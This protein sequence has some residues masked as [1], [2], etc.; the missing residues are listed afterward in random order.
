MSVFPSEQ[1]CRELIAAIHADPDSLKAG[2]GFAS[3]L[4]AIVLPEPPALAEPFAIWA[5]AVEG[6]VVE[7]RVLEDLDEVEE[8]EPPYVARAGYS[9]WKRLIQGELDPIEAILHR[10]IQLSGDLEPII[11]RAQFKELVRRAVAQ[12]PTTF[13]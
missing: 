11:E 3:E 7:F 13:R 6:R 1:W 4:A 2:R 8:I 9:T 12:V 5:R 10:Q